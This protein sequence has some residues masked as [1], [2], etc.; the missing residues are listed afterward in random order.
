MG[1]KVFID[2]GAK[3]DFRK[4]DKAWQR[5]IL[6]YLRSKIRAEEDP[7][8]FGDPLHRDLK[9]LWKYRIGDYRLICSIRDETVTVLVLKAGHRSNVY[10]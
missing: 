7:R 8:R 4:I 9:G 10:D 1:W 5:K 6:E 3:K 2:D